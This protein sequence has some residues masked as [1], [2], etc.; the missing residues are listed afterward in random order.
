MLCKHAQ[1]DGSTE[2]YSRF[3]ISFLF[4]GEGKNDSCYI[5]EVKYFFTLHSSET[6]FFCT[7][8]IVL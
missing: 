4:S 6:M 2:E 5:S 3:F 1:S 7:F 8:Y